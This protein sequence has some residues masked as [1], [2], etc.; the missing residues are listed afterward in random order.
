M[1]CELSLKSNSLLTQPDEF[2]S[3]NQLPVEKPNLLSAAGSIYQA[4]S[5]HFKVDLSANI[6]EPK[7]SDVEDILTLEFIKVVKNRKKKMVKKETKI[8]RIFK[9]FSSVQ[10]ICFLLL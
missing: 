8:I 5:T 10:D 7:M 1:N 9:K 3:K 6:T 2:Q 4:D